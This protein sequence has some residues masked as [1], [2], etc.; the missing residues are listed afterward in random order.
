MLVS[1]ESDTILKVLQRD[2]GEIPFV[3]GVNNHMGSRFTENKEKMMVV[4]EELK[5]RALYFVDS[6]TSRRS[7][8]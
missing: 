6:K 8:W 4:L 2:L 3:A 1:M 5:R 7:A